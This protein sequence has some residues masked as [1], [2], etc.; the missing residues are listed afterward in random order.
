MHRCQVSFSV[1]VGPL[2]LFAAALLLAAPGRAELAVLTNGHVLEVEAYR[3]EG[4][5]RVVLV[6]RTGGELGF[7]IGRIERIVDDEAPPIEPEGAGEVAGAAAPQAFELGFREGAAVPRA[8]YGDVLYGVAKEL[9]I[10]PQ[11]LA[12]IARAESANDPSALSHKGARGLMQLMPATAERFGVAAHQLWEPRR[13]VEAGARYLRFL[14]DRFD[15]ALPL[16]LAAYNAGE[17]AVGRYG[18]VPPYRETRDYVAR[19]LGYLGV[20]PEPSRVDLTS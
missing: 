7:E 1:A 14:I 18:G 3:L 20:E 8:A 5:E 10:N 19:V 15:G 6:L 12:A 16:V 13:N 4:A 17:G 9:G 2:W 11:L